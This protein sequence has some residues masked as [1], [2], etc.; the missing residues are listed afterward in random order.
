MPGRYLIEP[1]LPD[2][3]AALRELLQSTSM[4]GHMRLSLQREPSFFAAADL[5]NL[6]TSVMVGREAGSGRV[7]STAT[8]AIRRAYVDG[9][10]CQVGYLSSLRLREEARKTTLLARWYRSLKELHADGKAPY[11]VTTILRGNEDA[12]RVLT[13]GRAGLPA[14]VPVG[15]LHT[16]L[17]PLYGRRRRVRGGSVVR[18]IAAE[19]LPSA[20][21]CLDRFNARLQ[22]AP[23]YKVE[24]FGPGSRMLHGLSGSDLYLYL[25]GRD[26]AGTMAVWDQNGFKQSVVAGYS[27]GLSAIRPALALAARFGWAPR[28]PRKGQSLPCLFAALMSSRESDADVFRDLVDTVLAERT[29]TG[30]A[31]LLLGLCD[32]HPFR[33]VVERLSVMTIVSEIYLVYWRDCP[34]DSLPS[35]DRVP[36]LEIATL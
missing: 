13:S 29:N 24:D 3:D 11:Y 26:V 18:G 1:A 35:M 2:D 19:T 33:G 6:A 28:L 34:P 10:E 15:V 36:H 5:G 16:Y 30:Y 32:R 14:Y 22:F 25:H 9:R 17:L 12:R 4:D 23:A 20:L 7:L 31:Y 21:A 8:R 27:P